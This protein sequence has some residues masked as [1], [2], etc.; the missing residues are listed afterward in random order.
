MG[1]IL[2]LP[3]FEKFDL[4]SGSGD[5]SEFEYVNL[6]SASSLKPSLLSSAPL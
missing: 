6:V 2:V 4:A 5:G 3:K 1:E